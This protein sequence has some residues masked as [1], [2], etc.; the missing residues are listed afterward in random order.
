MNCYQSTYSCGKRTIINKKTR[1]IT[2]I[3]TLTITLTL[4]TFLILRLYSASRGSTQL[5]CLCPP[6]EYLT[7][8]LN[9]L[10]IW[11]RYYCT[12]FDTNSKTVYLKLK[13]VVQTASIH[14]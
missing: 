12:D 3:L 9:R 10:V 6:Q 4:Y 8:V 14:S 1:E 13:V 2:T 5:L 7:R 11:V